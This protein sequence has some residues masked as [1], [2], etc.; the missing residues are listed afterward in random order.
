MHVHSSA[1]ETVRVAEWCMRTKLHVG[2]KVMLRRWVRMMGALA[3]CVVAANIGCDTSF[4]N[5]A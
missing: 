4:G 2:A 3:P 1:M 5:C